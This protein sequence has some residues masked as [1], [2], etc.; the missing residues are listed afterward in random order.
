MYIYLCIFVGLFWLL[1]K[2][3]HP[4]LGS[5]CTHG[6]RQQISPHF[7]GGNT[8]HKVLFACLWPSNQ[9]CENSKGEVWFFSFIPQMLQN[10]SQKGKKKVVLS[11]NG[12][13]YFEKMISILGRPAANNPLCFPGKGWVHSILSSTFSDLSALYYLNIWST[14][15]LIPSS[16]SC[17]FF[18]HKPPQPWSLI[19]G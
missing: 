15:I 4:G 5:K 19:G 18:I 9:G 2:N 16:L 11:S 7:S 13:F 10:S 12:F 14:N 17:N 6:T 1:P 8:S 3:K